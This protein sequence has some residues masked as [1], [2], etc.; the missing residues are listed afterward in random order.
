MDV[1]QELRVAQ[2]A[3]QQGRLTKEQLLLMAGAE[4]GDFPHGMLV[5]LVKGVDHTRVPVEI[6]ELWYHTQNALGGLE[7]VMRK[8]HRMLTGG[9]G[10]D[11]G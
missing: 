9:S 5:L 1:D 8:A 11:R 3:G 10:C 2:A 4:E 7:S 6:E